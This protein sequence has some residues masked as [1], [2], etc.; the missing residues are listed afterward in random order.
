MSAVSFK[1]ETRE[2][3]EQFE[4]LML[5][6][7]ETRSQSAL[8]HIPLVKAWD[9]LHHREDGVRVFTA[10]LDVYLNLHMV[11]LDLIT[12]GGT[13]NS[14]FSKGKLEGGSVLDSREKFFGKMDIHRYASSF[15]LRYRAIWDK[16][17]GL[18]L[19]LLSPGAY[20]KFSKSKSKKKSFRDA[21][22]KA[23]GIPQ[24]F[25]A[26]LLSSLEKFDNVFRTPEAHG[27]GALRK[28]SL[29]MEGLE[30]NPM[31]ELIKHWNLLNQTMLTLGKMFR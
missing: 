13:W 31:I 24:D 12:V 25:V 2:D 16:I 15:I 3:V 20:D 10:L 8:D 21:A 26:D 28:W 29:T 17:M 14:N 23:G 9:Y 1:L 27:T 7:A 6:Y 5:Q 18:F 11:H 22:S 30:N 4:A 19:L